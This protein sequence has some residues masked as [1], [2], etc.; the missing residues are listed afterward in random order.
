MHAM[1][2]GVSFTPAL[3]LLLAA[4]N[5]ALT[6][7]KAQVGQCLVVQCMQTALSSLLGSAVVCVL[8]RQLLRPIRT[9]LATRAPAL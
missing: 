4:G 8:P 9:S 2:D 7:Q 6:E 5:F 1:C 3:L